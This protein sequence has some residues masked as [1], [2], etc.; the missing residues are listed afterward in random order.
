MAFGVGGIGQ[1][2]LIQLESLPDEVIASLEV[3]NAWRTQVATGGGLEFILYGLARW[4]PGSTVRVAFLDGDVSLHAD[5][6]MATRQITDA[7]NLRLDFG[8]DAATGEYR[9]WSES[10]ADYAAEIRVSFDLDGYWSLI[11]TDSTDRT[12]GAPGRPEGGRP[13]QRSLNLGGFKSSRP[14]DW[15]GTVRHELLHALAFQHEHQNKRGLCEEEFRWEDD[16]RYTPTKD[17]RGVFIPDQAGRCPG[18]YTYLAGAPNY[19]PRQKVDHNLRRI[20]TPEV[21]TGSFD[22]ASIMLYSFDPLFYKTTPSPCAPTGNGIDLSAGD[23]RGLRLLYP[24][25][26]GGMSKVRGQAEEVLDRIG[27]RHELGLEA[28]RGDDSPYRARVLDL[29]S[30]LASGE[31]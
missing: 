20:T 23:R 24:S 13:H 16:S 6:E 28:T 10:D 19:W 9:R 7:C 30:Y 29:L 2:S 17:K 5:I 14:A 21:T 3:R 8:W 31:R 25:S 26:P 12:V 1:S 22:S 27:A 4:R 18:I 15:Q 11:G